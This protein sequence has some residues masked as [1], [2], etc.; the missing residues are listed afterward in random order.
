MFVPQRY[1]TLA[2]TL[3]KAKFSVWIH[4]PRFM[5]W[6]LRCVLAR[7]QS[8]RTGQICAGNL[9]CGRGYKFMVHRYLLRSIS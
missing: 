3:T 5:C 4:T 9:W 7:S 1:G 8:R 6:G 2:I